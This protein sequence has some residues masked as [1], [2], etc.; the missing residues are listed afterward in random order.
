MLLTLHSN[1]KEEYFLD[2]DPDL[3]KPILQWYRT[4]YLYL[5]PGVPREAME[6]ELDFYGI[7]ISELFIIPKLFNL[8]GKK[9]WGC[10]KCGT[11]LVNNK[12]VCSK[13]FHSNSGPAILFNSW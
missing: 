3:F 4:G 13:D 12:E 7:P 11:S 5:P 6:A 8:Q 1:K 9:I 2:R 10:K